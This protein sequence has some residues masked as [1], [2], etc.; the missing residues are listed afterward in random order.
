L[1][2]PNPPEADEPSNEKSAAFSRMP[3]PTPPVKP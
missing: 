1:A 2:L 3:L